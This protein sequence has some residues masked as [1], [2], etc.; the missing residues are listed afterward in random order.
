MD[1]VYFK[2]PKNVVVRRPSWKKKGCL[3][4]GWVLCDKDGNVVGKKDKKEN[5]ENK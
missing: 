5:K 2:N 1:F 3:D 4:N